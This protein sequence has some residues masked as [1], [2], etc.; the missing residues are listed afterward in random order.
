MKKITIILLVAILATC[1]VA[2]DD[3]SNNGNNKD[4]NTTTS[5][6]VTE[7][8]DKTEKDDN[9]SPTTTTKTEEKTST[10]APEF[11]TVKI[12]DVDI[13]LPMDFEEFLQKTGFKQEGEME[14]QTAYI[15]D[16][17]SKFYV[18]VD[19]SNNKV[20]RM[21]LLSSS[22]LYPFDT[23]KTK[24]IFPSGATLDTLK[25]ELSEIYPGML[26]EINAGVEVHY[27]WKFSLEKYNS[28]YLEFR[29][30]NIHK[31]EISGITLN[32]INY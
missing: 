16:G 8:T 31:E 23:S 18:V 21:T 19:S 14:D 28:S 6:K 24:I 7:K 29:F 3:K 20:I 10:D 32:L 17:Y 27:R 13:T 1:F 9:S 5:A 4:K 30:D 11:L 12:N 26:E 2:C 15:T 22:E 25:S